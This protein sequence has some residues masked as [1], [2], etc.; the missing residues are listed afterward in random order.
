MTTES[1]SPLVEF[2]NQLADLVERSHP[3]I[4]AVNGQRRRSASGIHW[5]SGLIVTTDHT[6]HREDAITITL[7]DE[8]TVAATLL[9]RDPG[10]DIAVLQ[11]PD[12][13]I[14]TIAATGPA[15][16]KVGQ[17]VLAIARSSENGVSASMGVISTVGGSWRSWKGGK[18]DQFIRP[19]LSIY[20]GF[21]GSAL[22]DMQGQVIGMNTAGP[23]QMTMTIPAATIHRVVE[24]LLSGGRAMRG[25]LGLGMQAIQLPDRLQNSLQLTQETGVIVVSVEPQAPAEQAGVL[26]GDI[27]IRL[28]QTAIQ[29]VGDVL[30]TLDPERIG[31][32]ITATLI[33]G[34]VLMEITIIVGERPTQED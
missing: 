9:G 32:P 1:V 2:S 5:R 23:R 8:G 17:C 21:S 11:V 30:A 25:Y 29:A 22:V 10:T 18:I 33:R 31:H 34:G 28:D 20:P 12:L 26:I 7:A 24:Y 13:G 15:A 4:V 27:L 16:V 19:A 14:P 6:L 3:A